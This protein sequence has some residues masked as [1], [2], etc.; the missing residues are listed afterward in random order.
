MAGKRRQGGREG[1][2]PSLTALWGLA[3]IARLVETTMPW[4][5]MAFTAA[6][7]EEARR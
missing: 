7:L 5:A 2:C 6:L 4:V 1:S 3:I